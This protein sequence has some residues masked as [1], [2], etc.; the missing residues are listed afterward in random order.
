MVIP[1]PLHTRRWG[2]VVVVNYCDV[3]KANYLVLCWR[4]C[5]DMCGLYNILRASQ[6]G[7][8]VNY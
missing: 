4:L 8:K 6:L 5:N 7:K 1:Y 2:G 3:G